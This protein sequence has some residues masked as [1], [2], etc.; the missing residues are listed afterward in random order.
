MVVVD[1]CLTATLA[2]A[3]RGEIFEDESVGHNCLVVVG[4]G[5]FGL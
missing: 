2:R 1:R 5:W 3:G 4:G